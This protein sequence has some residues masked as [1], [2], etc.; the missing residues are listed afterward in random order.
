[1]RQLFIILILAAIGYFGWRYYQDRG[2]NLPVIPWISDSN[3]SDSGVEG[4]EEAESP[5]E[6]EP[7]FVSKIQI[8]E[9]ETPGAKPTAPPG[10]FYMIDRVSTRTPN[11]VIAVIPGE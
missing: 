9:P 1:M 6:P 2:G 4:E 8:P 5:S 3:Q 11:G 10:M 7:V